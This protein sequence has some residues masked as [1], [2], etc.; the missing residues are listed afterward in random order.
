MLHRVES[1]CYQVVRELGNFDQQQWLV[2]TSLAV[3]VGVFL[4][5]GY[6]SRSF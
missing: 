1:Y 3:V 6:G 4:L 2:V 5:R